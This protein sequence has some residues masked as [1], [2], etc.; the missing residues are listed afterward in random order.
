MPPQPSDLHVDRMLTQLAVAYRQDLSNFVADRIF[1]SIP[2]DKQSDTYRI[3]PRDWWLRTFA[4]KR[5]PA[6]ES[7]G[8]D[9]EYSEDSY[10]AEK[11]SIHADVPDEDRANEDDDLDI[12]EDATQLTVDQILLKK[13]KDFVSTYMQTGVWDTDVDV[14]A[15]STAWTTAATATPLNDVADK[16]LAMHQVTGRMANTIA[17][18][19]PTFNALRFTDQILDRI[20][21]G[22]GN[23]DPANV[24]PQILAGLFGVDRVFLLGAVENSAGQAETLSMDWVL[25]D[26]LWLGYVPPRPSPRTPSAGYTFKWRGAAGSVDGMRT[27]RFR[28]DH[29]DAERVETDDYRDE[30]VVSAALGTFFHNTG[31]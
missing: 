24:T 25:S 13:E 3:Y 20:I 9:W 28:M 1:P 17:M 14:S 2:V 15:S 23:A 19:M 10:F 5:A 26:G 21:Y 18:A 30:K 6:T 27:K 29:L 8:I 31:A 7:R 12:F 11:Y 22:G 16:Q 4:D